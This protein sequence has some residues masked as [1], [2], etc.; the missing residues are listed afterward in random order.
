M[1]IGQALLSQTDVD[2]ASQK[3]T[4]TLDVTNL[5]G[6]GDWK[7]IPLHILVRRLSTKCTA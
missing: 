7:D 6:R 2:R 1:Y 3:G 4:N 5:N